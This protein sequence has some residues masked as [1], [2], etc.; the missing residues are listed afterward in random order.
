MDID[1]NEQC[2]AVLKCPSVAFNCLREKGHSGDH[3]AMHP[4]PAEYSAIVDDNTAST[5]RQWIWL[6]A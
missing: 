4:S 2:D 3:H 6:A 5:L 1:V